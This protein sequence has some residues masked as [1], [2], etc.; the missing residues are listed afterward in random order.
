MALPLTWAP[1]ARQDFRELIAY[2][3]DSDL[4][5]AR[6]FGRALLETVER[7]SDFPRSG[8]VVPEFN[9]P[10]FAK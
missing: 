6:D 2:I 3:A 4:H 1:A 5:A 7:L 10:R 9:D 8:R